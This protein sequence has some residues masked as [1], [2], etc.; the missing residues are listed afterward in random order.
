MPGA[1]K[2]L[3]RKGEAVAAE[4]YRRQG[5][6]LLNH[7]YRTRMGEL[8]LILYKEGALVIAEVK[9]RSRPGP[10]TPGAAVN[11]GKQRRLI[12]AARYYLQSSPFA[13]AP[14]RFDVVEVTPAGHGWQ[15]H[16]IR[17]A[18]QC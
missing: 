10:A 11:A 16:C 6:I 9:T 8:D 12:A 18:F 15:V 17:D 4:Y 7:N 14:V 13:D 5:Y 2:A 1:D 3:G